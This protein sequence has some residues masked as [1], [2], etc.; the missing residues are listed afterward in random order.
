MA[1]TKAWACILWQYGLRRFPQKW[2]L[3]SLTGPGFSLASLSCVVL[4]TSEYLFSSEFWSSPW[5]LTPKVWT[6]VPSPH[7]V[8]W[9]HK[10]FLDRKFYSATI[11]VV[12]PLHFASKH[13]LLHSSLMFWNS[14]SHPWV[15]FQMCGIFSSFT[16]SCSGYKSPSPNPLSLFF[17]YLLPSLIIRSLACIFGSLAP[18]P[19]FRRC[20]VG[21]DLYEDELFVYLCVGRWSPCLIPQPSWKSS[22]RYFCLLWL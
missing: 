2:A 3:A 19:A 17:L 6:H 13:L 20:S 14:P 1:D 22:Q 4:D 10:P 5:R 8:C 9:T 16:T 15:G 7:L 11:S 18:L 12:N 21:A